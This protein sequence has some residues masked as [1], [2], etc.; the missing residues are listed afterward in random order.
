MNTAYLETAE[1]IGA[2]L[3]RDALWHQGRCNWTADFLDGDQI[4][5]G[6]LGPD[7]YD[8]T[9]GI[10]LFLR[11]LAALTGERIFRLT[12]EAALRQALNNLPATGCGLYSGR[13]GV[14]CRAA[15]IRQELDERIVIPA[16]QPDRSHLDVIDG[17]A[18]AIVALLNLHH[19]APSA[20][21]LDAAIEHGDFLLAEA[22]EEETAGVGKP[23]RPRAISPGSR[24]ARPV[25]DGLWRSSTRP[26]ERIG[27]AALHAKPSIMNAPA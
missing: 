15:E 22:S 20:R 6:A 3:C 25:S 4:A 19:Q 21:L 14:L 11:R 17:S 26:P 16:I 23:P 9:S 7:L 13:L 24:T 27:F 8:G 5:H 1:R 2:R 18:G 12:G 10:A